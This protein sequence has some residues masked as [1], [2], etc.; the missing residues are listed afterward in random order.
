[1][2]KHIVIFK[3]TPPLYEHEK[4]E[5]LKKLHDIFAPLGQKLKYI[6]EYRTASTCIML[7]LPVI[8]L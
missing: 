7:K 2:I 1:M 3:L 4:A 6:I 8:S 5:S